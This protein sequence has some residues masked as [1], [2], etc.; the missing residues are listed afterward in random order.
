MLALE[1]TV[2]GKQIRG[3]FRRMGDSRFR[4][5]SRGFHWI[6]EWPLNR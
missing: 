2:D 3:R 1:G 4:L 6:N 5:I